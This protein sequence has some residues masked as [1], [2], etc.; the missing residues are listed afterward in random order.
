VERLIGLPY[1]LQV[2]GVLSA[3]LGVQYWP[4]L[5]GRSALPT[6]FLQQSPALASLRSSSK[7]SQP[8]AA[9]DVILTNKEYPWQVFN[10]A[11]LRHG[12]LPLWDPHLLMGV[13]QVGS[14]LPAVF[15]PWHLGYLLM[16]V[17]VWW[18]LLFPLHQLVA[19]LGA[20]LLARR[21]TGS[22]VGGLVAGL[23]YGLG[24]FV[25]GHNGQN[26]GEVAVML[27]FL[28]LALVALADRPTAR[29]AIV[30]GLVLAVV[31]LCGH[32]ET[33]TVAVI[34]AAVLVVGLLFRPGS[35]ARRRFASL[36]GLVGLVALGCSAIQ[37]LP[38]LPWLLDS[39]RLSSRS[40]YARP[41]GSG[42]LDVFSRNTSLGAVTAPSR[43]GSSSYVGTGGVALALFGLSRWRRSPVV[44][45]L[46]LLAIVSALVA[47]AIEPL[48]ALVTDVPVLQHMRLHFLL[49]D[50]DMSLA[51]LAAYGVA[52]LRSSASKPTERRRFAFAYVVTAVCVG[53]GLV[54]LARRAG[55]SAT[56]WSLLTH[57]WLGEA[58][59]AAGVLALVLPEVLRRRR[60]VLVL[61][62]VMALDLATWPIGFVEFSPSSPSP[63]RTPPVIS[64]L[65]RYDPSRTY[66]ILDAG[67]TMPT[68][69]ALSIGTSDPL[70]DGV[71]E[72][73]AIAYWKGL[74]REPRGSEMVPIA[75]DLAARPVQRL[76]LA[77]VK[78]L[79]VSTLKPDEVESY[80]HST[81]GFRFLFSVGHVA[82]FE[83][84]H[85]LGPA[86][87]V[88]MAGVRV[89]G[90][91][92][93]ARLIQ[94]PTFAPRRQAVLA[95]QVGGTFAPGGT[96]SGACDCVT[97]F[98]QAGGNVAFTVSAKR[99]SV[100]VVSQ[101]WYP[102]WHATVD[103]RPVP[104]TQADVALTGLPVP[105]G[106]SRVTLTFHPSAMTAGIVIS[107]AAVVLSLLGLCALGE[108]RL[109]R[110]R[111]PARSRP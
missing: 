30:A 106:R 15:D 101:S 7:V 59:V 32:P 18:N 44:I 11:A 72:A 64:A 88:P 6:R 23:I 21:L 98:R 83:N 10:T 43:P 53:A 4:L 82:V 54:M 52:W 41:Q 17:L 3:L 102:G 70:G 99:P 8:G 107:A 66:R 40:L 49:M 31:V 69:F 95:A 92:A 35:Q 89:G 84:P 78:Y 36:L 80:R 76:D 25:E 38:G 77:N 75:R 46:G 105:A 94:A 14:W 96:D 79:L 50:F 58:L 108:V 85:D 16:P 22:R 60:F 65:S 51:L 62:A 28:L 109:S 12:H 100:V 24:G 19:G 56:G 39:A 73:E 74:M 104:V 68:G 5:L 45:A 97:S 26:Q 71:Y 67:P 20:A 34:G 29:R 63:Y 90:K 81:N 110:R 86:V 91:A 111:P 1:G 103:G 61:L 37:W 93:A 42:L 55:Q 87:V 47:Y 9:R 13:P 33:L 57:G 2:A 48:H 27:P